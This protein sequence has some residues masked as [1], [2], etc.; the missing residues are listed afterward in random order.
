M[1][2][3][4]FW[5][6]SLNEIGVLVRAVG[7]YR[8]FVAQVYFPA[9]G[10][11]RWQRLRCAPVL[12][13]VEYLVYRVDAVAELTRHASF[14][15]ADNR[16]LAILEAYKERF[17]ALLR[18]L[19]AY[20][21]AIAAQL[22]LGE[23]FVRLENKATSGLATGREDVL[24]LAELR[25]TDVRLLHLM[26]FAL[27]RQSVDEQ[28]VGLLWPVEVLAD[29]A[30]DLSH[31]QRDVESSTF[32]VLDSFTRLYGAAAPAELRAVMDHYEA[33]FQTLLAG[34]PADRRADLARLCTRRFRPGIDVIPVPRLAEKSV[35]PGSG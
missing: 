16:R 2:R 24:R 7:I 17:R 19:H 21:D 20:N 22:D 26:I 28:L 31:Y 10:L 5:M 27:T 30:N 35:A 3:K 29:I 15:D 9:Q 4:L 23:E 34:F 11:S 18:R 25:S 1:S 6:R 14:D 12:L 32:N 33:Q 8:D 13:L